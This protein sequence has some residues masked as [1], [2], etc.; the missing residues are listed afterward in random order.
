MELTPVPNAGPIDREAYSSRDA[1]FVMNVHAR[2]ENSANDD[3]CISWVRRFFKP[4]APYASE[5]A[6]VNFMTEEE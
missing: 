4:A 6:Y 3:K 5:G 2:W 1:K